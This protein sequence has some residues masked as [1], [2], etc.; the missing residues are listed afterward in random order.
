ML[1]FSK[2]KSVSDN[3]PANLK[4]PGNARVRMDTSILCQ[5]SGVIKLLQFDAF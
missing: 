4:N 1:N 3:R 5:D 2:P